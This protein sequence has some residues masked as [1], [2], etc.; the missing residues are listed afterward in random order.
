MP[1]QDTHD[2]DPF[3]TSEYAWIRSVHQRTGRSALLTSSIIFAVA[4]GAV[5]GS[6]MFMGLL[7]QWRRDG[8]LI[9]MLGV[10]ALA[11][12]ILIGLGIWTR[13]RRDHS[14]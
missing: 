13:L 6:F 11:I 3:A 4:G 10:V 5:L 7:M 9:Y 2:N 12:V 14:R 1:T 8:P